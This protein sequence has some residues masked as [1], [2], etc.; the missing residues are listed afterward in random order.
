MDGGREGEAGERARGRRRGRARAP[1]EAGASGAPLLLSSTRLSGADGGWRACRIS[2]PQR[3]PC[4]WPWLRSR[5]PR[6]LPSSSPGPSNLASPSSYA[7][8]GGTAVVR[9]PSPRP[10]EP[11]QPPPQPPLPPASLPATGWTRPR[12]KQKI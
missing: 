1:V 6:A 11:P 10:T 2:S 9:G 3:R 7:P 12:Q 4:S 5:A 8:S